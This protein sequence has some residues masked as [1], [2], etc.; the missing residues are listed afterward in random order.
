M[1]IEIKKLIGNLASAK[2]KL[3]VLSEGYTSAQESQFY[4]DVISIWDKIVNYYP[5]TGLRHHN[6]VMGVGAAFIPSTN[7]GYAS[8]ATA[9][10]GYNNFDTYYDSTLQKLI[11]DRT[12]IDSVIEDC[13]IPGNFGDIEIKDL[14][15]KHKVP[16]SF[17]STVVL[18]LLPSSSNISAEAESL[19]ENH[20]YHIVSTNDGYI[21]QLIIRSIAKII[22]LGDEFED[23]AT[24]DFDVA[25]AI[26][27][28][29]PNLYYLDDPLNAPSTSDNNFK[30]RH[31]FKASASSGISIVPN[32]S[33]NVLQ[34]NSV[35]Y[36]G[37]E[38]IE[39]GG[40]FRYKIYRSNP[41][42]LLRRNIGDSSLKVKE[43]KIGL[44]T[45]CEFY[46]RN[47]VK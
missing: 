9:A 21:E 43:K 11:T 18:V 14:V 25:N 29:F 42:C 27:S 8:G 22:G 24:L 33:L 37:I 46:L 5:F 7:S 6:S 2:F 23:T 16:M 28:I 38:L 32:I 1:S 34:T 35:S 20:Y 13:I 4:Q 47:V 41:D 26:H 40:G 45:I 19:D 36:K 3:I 15:F 31:F 10:V 39:G 12:K 30:W 44:C 17:N